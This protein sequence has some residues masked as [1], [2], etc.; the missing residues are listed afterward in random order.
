MCY[1]SSLNNFLTLDIKHNGSVGKLL[2]FIAWLL[3][4][5][6]FSP[7]FTQEL[8]F[9]ICFMYLSAWLLYIF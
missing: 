8:Q 1:V 7:S 6:G 3:F 2:V 5:N 4:T 9:E